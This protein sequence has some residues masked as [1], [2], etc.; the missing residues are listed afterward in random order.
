M[1]RSITAPEGY[2][3][4]AMDSSQIELR[5]GSYIA[6]DFATLDMFRNGQDPYSVQ[7]AQLYGGDPSE[8]KALAKKGVQP[9]AM[10]RQLSK[11]AL[12][13]CIYGTGARGFQNYLKVN[14]LDQTED[15]CQHI[16]NVYRQTHPEIVAA[17]KECERALQGMMAGT[18]GYFGGPNGKMFYYDGS[19]KIHGRT[20][21]GIRLPDGNWLNYYNL[22]KEVKEYPDGTSKMNFAYT[23]LKEGSVRTIFTYAS[24]IFE[25]INQAVAFAVM[26]YQAMLINKRYQ[27]AGNTHDEWFVVVPDNQIAEATAYIEWCMRQV[28]PW[29]EGLPLDCEGSAAKR[30]GDCK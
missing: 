1:K 5:T 24:K 21:A 20:V 30:Y 25:N 15:E 8:I 17:W 4:I 14:A 6:N 18:S 13:S 23:G 10:Q 9:Q 11:S 12:L 16:V 29:A 27:V 22:R 28:P 7:A 26:K 2:S 3:V 19:R